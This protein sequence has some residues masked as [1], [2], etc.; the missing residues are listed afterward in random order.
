MKNRELQRNELGHL[1]FGGCDTVDLANEYGTPLYVMDVSYIKKQ[2]RTLMDA[3]ASHFSNYRVYYASKAFCCKAICQIASKEGL[4]LDTVSQGELYTALE[5]GFDPQRINNHGNVKTD[6]DI[7]LCLKNGVGIVADSYD[8]LDDI[9]RLAKEMGKCARVI[10]RVTPGIEAHTHEY[11][12]TGTSDCKFALGIDNG[13]AMEAIRRIQAFDHMEFSGIHAH[14]G[15][16]IMDA[17]SFYHAAV[18]MAN[19]AL[20]IQD[21][22]G[23]FPGEIILGGGFGIYYTEGDTRLPLPDFIDQLARG[24]QEVLAPKM[25]TMPC[26]SIEPGRCIVG[27]AGITLYRVHTVKDVPGIQ[28]FVGVDGG[29]AD[30]ARVTLYQA[31]YDGCVANRMDVPSETVSTIAGRCCESGDILI[32]DQPFA[33]PQKGDIIAIFS[34]GAYGYS[35]ASNYNRL[36]IPPVVFVENGVSKLVIKGQT[37]QDIMQYDLGWE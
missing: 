28:H 8:E 35:M 33:D 7:R 26:I 27:E 30:N 13:M 20:S 21:E 1:V 24:I 37:P 23:I 4:C 12:R 14:I 9:Q 31:K 10:V 6:S 11:I 2:M 17:E 15:S 32:K 22:L 19:F 36:G 25:Q 18:N 16:Q 5:A 29:M 3:M 34:T